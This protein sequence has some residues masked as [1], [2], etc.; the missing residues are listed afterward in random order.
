MANK[1]H[2]YGKKNDHRNRGEVA[3][4]FKPVAPVR[5]VTDTEPAPT[6]KGGQVVALEKK[7]WSH[8]MIIRPDTTHLRQANASARKRWQ[9]EVQQGILAAEAK[10]QGITPA[11]LIF[12]RAQE[13][14][15]IIAENKKRA[16]MAAKRPVISCRG[17][18]RL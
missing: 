15:D 10:S 1:D 2:R 7:I 8:L 14:C 9:K 17:Q 12:K 11:E 4:L 6:K 13:V 5:K 3:R 16:A 18:Q